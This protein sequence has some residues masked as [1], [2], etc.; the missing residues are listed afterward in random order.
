MKE[1]RTVTSNH[2]NSESQL[3]KHLCRQVR[4]DCRSLSGRL[5]REQTVWKGSEAAFKP[6]GADVQSGPGAGGGA[7][8]GRP[9]SA[10]AVGPRGHPRDRW[11]KV[12]TGYECRAPGHTDSLVPFLW[13]SSQSSSGPQGHQQGLWKCHR[14]TQ[15]EIVPSNVPFCF[16][17]LGV[18][19]SSNFSNW[20]S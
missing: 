4:R 14:E 1:E 15:T 11:G 10:P 16:L 8:Q 9:A 19:S 13:S 7:G 5:R 3:E 20:L 18:L 2:E 12:G 6:R 17:V